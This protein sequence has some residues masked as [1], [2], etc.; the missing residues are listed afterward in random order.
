MPKK[1][2]HLVR[3]TTGAMLLLDFHYNSLRPWRKNEWNMYAVLKNDTCV[4][5]YVEAAENEI[6]LRPPR[7]PTAWV[8]SAQN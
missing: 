4:V 1:P 8:R 6:I 2:A 7:P 3:P 5:G